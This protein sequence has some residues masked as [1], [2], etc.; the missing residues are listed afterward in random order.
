MSARIEIPAEEY[1]G[2]KSK[3]KNLESALNSVSAEAALH[4]E[5]FEKAK[6]LVEDLGDETFVNRL[7]RWKTIITSLKK[8]F[9]E[10]DNGKIQ[11]T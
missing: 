4:K 5:T 3:I 11:K 8:A 9:T 2:M 1:Q 10:I 7:F 6:A